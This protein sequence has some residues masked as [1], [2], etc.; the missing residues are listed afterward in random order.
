MC[1]NARQDGYAGTGA[2]KLLQ[3]EQRI[4]DQCRREVNLF[5]RFGDSQDLPNPERGLGHRQR[6]TCE[7]GKPH[8][9]ATRFDGIFVSV[10]VL[11]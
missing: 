10:L 1:G 6:L 11:Q 4:A 9:L 8:R 5:L 3:H 2:H 7:V